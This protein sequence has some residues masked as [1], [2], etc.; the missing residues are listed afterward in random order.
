M[1]AIIYRNNSAYEQFLAPAVASREG[2]ETQVFPQGTSETEITTWL[3]EHADWLRSMVKVYMDQTCYE[4]GE[5]VPSGQP[6]KKNWDI[7][8]DVQTNYG[9]FDHQV[10]QEAASV[11]MTKATVEETVA[12]VIRHLLI[13][14]VPTKVLV[15]QDHMGDHD[16][17]NSKRE[18]PEA[19]KQA[20]QE[21][22]EKLR[23]CLADT[24]GQPAWYLDVSSMGLD[25][26]VPL[27]DQDITWVFLDRHFKGCEKSLWSK[28]PAT[29]RQFRVPIENLV[30]DAIAFGIEL[31]T[32]AYSR[33]IREI[34]AT[35]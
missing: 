5:A 31:D 2:F 21:D 33:T 1:K 18:G 35:W 27:T 19:R 13:K 30:E 4:A 28:I 34:V 22:A 6:D 29:F 26:G 15:I 3:A 10:F 25:A 24:I 20:T 32:E 8:M 12:E 11:L 14:E 16:L 17:F 23:R 7:W 9:G